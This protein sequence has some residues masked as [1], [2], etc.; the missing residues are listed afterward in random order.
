MCNNIFK[1]NKMGTKTIKLKYIT[2]NIDES[3]VIR[4]SG[5]NESLQIKVNDR[6]LKDVDHFK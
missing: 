3:Q 2:L 6:E 1:I 5:S 4:V